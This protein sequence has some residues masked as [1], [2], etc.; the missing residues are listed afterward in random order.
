[1]KGDEKSKMRLWSL[2]GKVEEI[3]GG[4]HRGG[5]EEG[6]CRLDEW[7]KMGME[8]A[9]KGEWLLILSHYSLSDIDVELVL[10][11]KPRRRFHVI[12][13]PVGGKGLAKKA[14]ES[15]VK[16]LLDASGSTYVVS[17]FVPFLFP[18]SFSFPR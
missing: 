1:V 6:R 4:H 11:S 5:E 2:R 7:V 15:S 16:P 17:R 10:D 18:F 13:N 8:S 9:Y 12:L 14:W 3:Q